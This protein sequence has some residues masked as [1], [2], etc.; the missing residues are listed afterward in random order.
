MAI[1]K[2]QSKTRVDTRSKAISSNNRNLA[3]TIDSPH[4]GQEEGPCGILRRP[5]FLPL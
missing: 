1:M 4:S 5:Y 2:D 3:R